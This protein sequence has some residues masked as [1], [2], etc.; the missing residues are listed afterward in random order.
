[1]IPVYHDWGNSTF[2]L[3]T[4]YSSIPAFFTAAAAGGPAFA[5][6]Q[7]GPDQGK[8]DD[9]QNYRADNNG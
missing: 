6:I 3:L 1:M 5:Y 7:D 9:P 8:G 4:A 2:S